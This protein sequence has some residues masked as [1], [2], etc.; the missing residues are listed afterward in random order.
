MRS[1][2]NTGFGPEIRPDCV[3]RRAG[4]YR[5]WCADFHVVGPRVSARPDSHKFGAWARHVSA[6]MASRLKLPTSQMMTVNELSHSKK[7][8]S[9]LSRYG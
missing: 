1:S 2:T 4:Q 7:P 8:E 5:S 9:V 3:C 6:E